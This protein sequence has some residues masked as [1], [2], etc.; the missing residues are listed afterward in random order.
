MLNSIVSLEHS[1]ESRKKHLLERM[2][3]ILEIPPDGPVSVADQRSEEMEKT[4]VE[5]IGLVNPGM[6]LNLTNRVERYYAE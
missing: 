1:E 5:A 6:F 4:A 2:P 3:A